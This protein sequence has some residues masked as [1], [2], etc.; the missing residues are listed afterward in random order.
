MTQSQDLVR[1][2]PTHVQ[3]LIGRARD[4]AASGKSEST[5]RAYR[6]DWIHFSEWCETHDLSSLPA[7][8][9]VVGLYVTSMAEGGY[10]TSTM[11]RRLVAIS[12]GHKLNG[13]PSPTTD[14]RVREIWRGIRRVVG[15]AQ[16]KKSPL[17]TLELRRIMGKL[18][19]ERLIDC[20]DAA[21]LL[22]GYAAA[23][24]RSELVSLDVEC[25]EERAEG[26]VIRL[27]RT[28][29]DQEGNGTQIGIPFGI[30]IETCPVR[31]L[32]R[33]IRVSGINS[34]PIF[35][36]IS[37]GGR[38]GQKGLS[39]R[40]VSLI[41]KKVVGSVG[42]NPDAFGGHSLR[43]GMATEASRNGSNERDI[44]RQTRHKSLNVLR[45]YIRDGE[46]F[47]SNAAATLGL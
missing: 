25:V 24:R 7:S 41:V 16:A 8:P 42:L 17:M 28:K 32:Q 38:V 45:G 2:D 3:I 35:R 36:A 6:S 39:P 10:A 46:L 27:G 9:E 44:M 33:W 40:A 13:H 26:I 20:R 34:G 37:K 30:N 4:Y 31:A 11:E 1:A 14:Q 15:G 12:Q 5:K 29:S 23:L 19:F 21:L 47:R 22:V 18:N 43:A